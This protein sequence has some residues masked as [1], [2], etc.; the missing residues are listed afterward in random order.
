MSGPPSAYY[1]QTM[2]AGSWVLARHGG[3]ARY[4]RPE[5]SDDARLAYNVCPILEAKRTRVVSHVIPDCSEGFDDIYNRIFMLSANSFVASNGDT[6]YVRSTRSCITGSLSVLYR[7]A[8]HVQ[9]AYYACRMLW[10]LTSLPGGC[11]A[12]GI[13]LGSNREKHVVSAFR[14]VLF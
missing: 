2:S 10:A 6:T 13:N 14:R 5:H 4:I 3:L 9:V 12:M 11:A 7:Q 8:I 1:R